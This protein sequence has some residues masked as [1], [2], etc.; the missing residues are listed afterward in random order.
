MPPSPQTR[1]P[2]LKLS[3][4]RRQLLTLMSVRVLFNT[5]HRMLYPFL[6]IFSRTLGITPGAFSTILAARSLLGATSPLLAW[7]GDRHGRKRGLLLGITLF[8]AGPLL[9]AVRPGLPT[10]VAGLMLAGIGKYTLDPVMQAFMGDRV[11]FARRG[12]AVAFVEL[13]WSLSYLL[14]VPAAGLLIARAGWLAPFPVLAVLGLL[15]LVALLLAIPSD[16]ANTNRDSPILKN[17]SLVLRSQLA[18]SGVVVGLLI[19][20]A[21][22]IFSVVF[23]LWLGRSFGFQQAAQ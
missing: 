19:S 13:G 21:N 8:T 9:I 16:P 1:S 17:L 23:G 11:P 6:E 14:G 7:I 2:T 12:R 20:A 18:V 15:A 10:F 5:P 4:L 3:P 22:E